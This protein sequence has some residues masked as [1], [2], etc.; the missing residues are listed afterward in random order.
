MCLS[1]TKDSDF[2]ENE[3]FL[4]RPKIV[5]VAKWNHVQSQPYAVG[6]QGPKGGPESSR[7]FSAQICILLLSR[8]SFPLISDIYFN[9]KNG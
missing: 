2:F 4:P 6:V 1:M 5:N 9:T 8:D 3:I 7:V